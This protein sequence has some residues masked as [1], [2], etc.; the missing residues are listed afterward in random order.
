MYLTIKAQRRRKTR[1]LYGDTSIRLVLLFRG[2][3]E[4]PVAQGGSNQNIT[5]P[6]DIRI[7]CE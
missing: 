2:V 7:F 6:L 5:L 1:D 3:H 4:L